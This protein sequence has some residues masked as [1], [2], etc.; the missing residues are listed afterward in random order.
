MKS[1]TCRENYICPFEYALEIISGKWRGLVL[2]Y[3]GLRGTLRYS[4]I[5]R[6][7]PTITQKMLTQTLRFLENEQLVD[8]KVYAVVPPK[9]EYKLTK[10]GKSLIPI[11]ENLQ[12]WG[13]K[14]LAT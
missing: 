7:L 12:E 8:R 1:S 13:K 5:K 6:E 9:V 3:L 2:F 10:K 14:Q 4:Q 11:L